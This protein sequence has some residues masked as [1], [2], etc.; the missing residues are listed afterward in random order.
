[1]KIL[2]SGASGQ[3]A[4]AIGKYWKWGDLITPPEAELDLAERE[5][6]A[7]AFQRFKPDIFVN[8]AAYTNVDAAETDEERATLINGT[9][10]GW[11]AEE[12]NSIDAMLIQ[13]STDYVFD[14]LSKA[15][16]REDDAV[17]PCNAYGRSKLTGE[18]AASRAAKC[19]ILR[20]A[21]LYDAWG[22]NFLTTM[23]KLA[24]QGKPIKV[25]SDQR[26]SPTSC[27]ALARQMEYAAK[28][29]W[30][31]LFHA[32][33]GGETTWHGFADAIFRNLDAPP[34]CSPCA[35]SEYPTPA[36]RPAY[37]VLDNAK[38]KLKGD[39][40]MGGWEDALQE[41]MGEAGNQTA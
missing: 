29:D 27:R 3:L 2:V 20:T 1:M 10:V 17:N 24:G 25:V 34:D 13:V 35:T 33:C 4:Q 41:V 11:I 5:S 18:V 40:L 23:L 16:C 8:C 31:G 36:G 6:I 39:D 21:W 30:R 38:R 28:N 12:C 37:S 19:L 14:G 32:T 7:S 15:P 9:A 22:K 26:G